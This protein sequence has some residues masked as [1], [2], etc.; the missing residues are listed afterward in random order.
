MTMPDDFD[1]PIGRA[2]TLRPG[3]RRIVAPN[4]SAMTYRGTN[5]YLLGDTE[6]AVIDPGPDNA[7]HLA[8][9]L[10]A[11]TPNQRITHIVVTHSHLDH[12]PLA[13]PLQDACGAEI[14]AFGSAEAG[15]SKI[16]KALAASGV[17]GG[18][19]G[20]DID[21]APDRT[22]ADGDMIRTKDWQLE[23]LHTPG[24]IGNHICLAWGECCFTADHVM[25]WASSLVSPPDGD[26]SDFMTSCER[27]GER[28]WDSFFPGH[29]DVISDPKG[30]LNWLINHRKSRETAILSA[31]R[32][33]PANARDLAREIYT[34]VPHE[35]H[36]AAA[37]N[38]LAHLIDLHKKNAVQFDRP[39][40]QNSVFSLK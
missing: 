8:A 7:S 9:I 6:I 22:V 19:E 20:V 11:V 39:L 5:T 13:R 35:L 23:V 37:R 33:K 30:R 12:A 38:V 26:L 17:T 15:R 16:M 1:P 2:E 21:F 27:L 40:A 14:Y 24:H 4:P 10:N 32:A 29:G 28:Q 36:D 18:G 34:E 3:L 31:L 25:G